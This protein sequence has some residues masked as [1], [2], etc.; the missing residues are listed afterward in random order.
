MFIIVHSAKNKKEIKPTQPVNVNNKKL[1]LK[2]LCWSPHFINGN[3]K[4]NNYQLSVA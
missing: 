3:K 4:K 2:A 1:F